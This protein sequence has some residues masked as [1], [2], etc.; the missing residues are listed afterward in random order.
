MPCLLG[1]PFA[2]FILET[3]VSMAFG[4]G[5][6]ELADVGKLIRIFDTGSV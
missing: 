3:A 4:I 5:V 6:S 2:C 1:H